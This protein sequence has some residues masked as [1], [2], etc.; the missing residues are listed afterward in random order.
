M[1]GHFPGWRTWHQ[2]GVVG[3]RARITGEDRTMTD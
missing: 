1:M 2:L 3:P